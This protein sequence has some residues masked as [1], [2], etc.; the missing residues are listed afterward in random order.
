[1][2]SMHLVSI[3]SVMDFVEIVGVIHVDNSRGG[4]RTLRL[5]NDLLEA[6]RRVLRGYLF[7]LLFQ[8]LGR[9][10]GT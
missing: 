3:N 9:F 8:D 4:V 1:M 2:V 10:W 6:G 5:L 7:P